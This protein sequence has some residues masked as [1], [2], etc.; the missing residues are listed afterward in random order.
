MT[1][2]KLRV[3]DA[4]GTVVVAD[5]PIA[6]DGTYAA[7]T[8]TGPAPWRIEACGY[9]GANYACLRSV[10]QAAGTANVTPLTEALLLLASGSRPMR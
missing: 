2:G 10:A 7:F 3:L 8:L 5:H 4:A 1:D 6:A 9:V